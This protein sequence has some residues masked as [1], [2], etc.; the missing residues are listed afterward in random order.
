MLRK[1]FSLRH[2][3][4]VFRRVWRL[5]LSPN[6]PAR[7]KLIFLAPAALYWVLPDVM[8]FMPVD[9]IAVTMLLMNW[10]SERMER[11]YKLK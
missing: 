3:S 6:I 7:E 10:F 8:P 11:R 9:D 4:H 1:L 5:L 2:W